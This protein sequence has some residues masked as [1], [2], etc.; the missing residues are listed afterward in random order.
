MDSGL[1]A[2]RFERLGV[3]S[4]CSAMVMTKEYRP[5]DHAQG[6]TLAAL[7]GALSKGLIQMTTRRISVEHQAPPS[8]VAPYLPESRRS[9]WTESVELRA[10]AFEDA[11]EGRVLWLVERA[12]KVGSP[13]RLSLW[14]EETRAN[15]LQHYRGAERAWPQLL[16]Y[17]AQLAEPDFFERDLALKERGALSQ[18]ARY[19]GSD[20]GSRPGRIL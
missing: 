9:A 18:E 16:D 8:S 15:R 14:R 20:S 1:A 3:E 12:G 10:A 5:L 13:A 19:L 2:R 4:A 17:F 7:R 6:E 11:S